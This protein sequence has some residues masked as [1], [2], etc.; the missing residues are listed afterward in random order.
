VPGIVIII[1]IQSLR[2]GMKELNYVA[3]T[4][5]AI[6]PEQAGCEGVL[7][8][9]GKLSADVTQHKNIKS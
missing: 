4:F 6:K 5:R 1:K 3:R 2:E 8:A 9:A 7:K